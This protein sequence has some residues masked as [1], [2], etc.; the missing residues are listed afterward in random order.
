MN[1]L[2]LVCKYY[3]LFVVLNAVSEDVIDLMITFSPFFSY[4]YYLLMKGGGF[5]I[6][7]N[8]N[9]AFANVALTSCTVSN[10]TAKYVSTSFFSNRIDPSLNGLIS[11]EL[12]HIVYS[13]SFLIFE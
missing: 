11:I 1:I 12:H 9:V 5:Y 13:P 3:L 6:V 2:F 7:N 4:L 8:A 10:N